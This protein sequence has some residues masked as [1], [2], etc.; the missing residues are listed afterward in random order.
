MN[1]PQVY[2]KLLIGFCQTSRFLESSVSI[3]IVIQSFSCF[4]PFVTPWSAARPASLSLT[5]SQS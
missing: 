5:I 2:M 4:R 3:V 1:P